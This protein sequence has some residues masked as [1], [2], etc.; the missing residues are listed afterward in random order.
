MRP[1]SSGR[2]SAPQW[3]TFFVSGTLPPQ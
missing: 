1:V 3:T 2:N